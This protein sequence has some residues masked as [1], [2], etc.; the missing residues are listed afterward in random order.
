MEKDK[1]HS[2]YTPWNARWIFQNKYD[3]DDEALAISQG[4]PADGRGGMYG[5]PVAIRKDSK[6]LD[7]YP[8]EKF[9]WEHINELK[10]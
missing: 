4:F 2:K 9:F 6:E 1:T 5:K 7:F 10:E 3:P 8:A